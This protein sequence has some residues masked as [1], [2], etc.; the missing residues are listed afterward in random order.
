[1]KGLRVLHKPEAIARRVTALGRQISRDFRGQTLDVVGLLDS[2]FLF[3]ADLVRAIQLP[4]RTHFI[5]A[6][7]QDI[8]DPDTGKERQEI[9]YSP[10]IEAEGK[11]ILLVKGLLGSGIPTDF[12][13]RRIALHRPRVIK[14]AVLIDKPEERKISV[15]PDY[16]AFRV[17]SNNIVMGYGLSQAGLQGNLPY[18]GLWARGRSGGPA[19]KRQRQTKRRKK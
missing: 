7:I 3:M 1:M 5:R 14:T 19:R 16:W 10:E 4:V 18:L 13:L 6:E 12:L 9:F 17:A 2:G 15:E 11:N 8:I